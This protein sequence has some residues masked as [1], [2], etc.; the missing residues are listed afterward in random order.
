MGNI[1]VQFGESGGSRQVQG[2][3]L[4]DCLCT[5]DVLDYAQH[6]GLLSCILD[7][8]IKREGGGLAEL[9]FVRYT[10]YVYCVYMMVMK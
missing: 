8:K 7:L 2:Q 9:Y 3:S 5:G 10:R 1:F 6:S 4:I